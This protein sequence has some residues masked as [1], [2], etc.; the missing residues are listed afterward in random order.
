MRGDQ[1]R[2]AAGVVLRLPVSAED[3]MA[4]T[5]SDSECSRRGIHNMSEQLNQSAREGREHEEE[6][7]EEW[8]ASPP[9][10]CIES[11]QEARPWLLRG[12]P[13]ACSRRNSQEKS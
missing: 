6:P 2:L 11:R 13:Y 5:G 9:C 4:D 12:L 7:E 8:R 1:V 3:F 10:R